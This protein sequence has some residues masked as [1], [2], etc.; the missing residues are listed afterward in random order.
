MFGSGSGTLGYTPQARLDLC[1]PIRPVVNDYFAESL[2][3]IHCLG[4]VRHGDEAQGHRP[5]QDMAFAVQK[6]VILV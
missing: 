5:D 3:N 2:R 1:G 4:F 6:V